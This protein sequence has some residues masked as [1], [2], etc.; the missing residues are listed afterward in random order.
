[1]SAGGKVFVVN[2]GNFM[3]GNASISL[4]DP[5]TNQVVVDYYKNQNHDT[6]GDV[7]QHLRFFN[8]SYYIVVNNSGKILICDR[9]MKK[10][11]EIKGLSS[12]RFILPLTNR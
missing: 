11:G 10:T 4:Y 8:G 1:M 2:E 9:E 5:A 7:A 6:V 3:A 12:P